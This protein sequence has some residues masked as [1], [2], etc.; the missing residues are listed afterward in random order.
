[1]T[2]WAAVFPV[3]GNET[4]LTDQLAELEVAFKTFGVDNIASKVHFGIV[5]NLRLLIDCSSGIIVGNEMIL[6]YINANGLT[7]AD[8]NSAQTDIAATQVVA[9]INQTRQ[10][11]TGLGF[12]KPMRFCNSDAESYFNNLVLE[13]ADCVVRETKPIHLFISY[14]SP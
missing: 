13:A 1:M 3:L 11:W 10:W 4:I 5:S 6:D 2:V 14:R 9:M 8:L 7:Q 12:D